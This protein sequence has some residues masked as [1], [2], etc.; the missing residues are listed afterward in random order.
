MEAKREPG[1]RLVYGHVRHPGPRGHQRS[2]GLSVDAL[3][4]DEIDSA[5]ERAKGAPQPTEVG[6]ATHVRTGDVDSPLSELVE[7]QAL[8][9]ER[10]HAYA[11]ATPGEL[12]NERRPHALGPSNRERRRHEEQP[13]R[14]MITV[15]ATPV[16]AHVDDRRLFRCCDAGGNIP[17]GRECTYL[18][19]VAPKRCERTSE[20][21]RERAPIAKGGPALPRE[22]NDRRASLNVWRM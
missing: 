18:D 14:H 13:H 11:E 16:P 8:L 7:E 1:T 4:D 5:V 22:S 6:S 15:A 21:R 19:D 2:H 3:A 9:D 20:L 17:S 10:H 12:W